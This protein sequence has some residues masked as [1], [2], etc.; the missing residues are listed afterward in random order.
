MSF[1]A[2]I[3]QVTDTILQSFSQLRA[4]F[5]AIDAAFSVNH[6]SMS[7]D[8]DVAGAHTALTMLPQAAMTTP[9]TDADQICLFTQLVSGIPNLFLEPNSNQKPIQLTYPSISNTGLIQQSF[10]A[11]PFIV[12]GGFINAPTQSQNVILSP[13][14]SLIYVDLTIAFYA[15]P[16]TSIPVTAVPANIT[17]MSFD[18]SLVNT[19]VGQSFGVYY[20]A[21]GLP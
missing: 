2:N 3:P 17:G 16:I 19:I 21:I 18:I 14:S 6:A 10:L 15:G 1:N 20:F 8:L 9:V 12:Y 4:N 13:G 7:G 11:G 5:Q